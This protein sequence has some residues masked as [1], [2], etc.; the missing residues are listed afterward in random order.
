MINSVNLSSLFFNI[1]HISAFV[2]LFHYVI[3]PVSLKLSRKHIA[4]FFNLAFFS[5]F[6]N[7]L[8]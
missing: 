5:M 3:Y 8:P 1:F 4:A 2:M 7:E 6:S